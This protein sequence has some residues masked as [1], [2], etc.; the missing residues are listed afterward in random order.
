MMVSKKTLRE[1]ARKIRFLL[2]DVDG[3]MTNGL[4]YL[5]ELGKEMKAFHIHDGH[6]I[7][8]LLKARLGVGIVTG[9]ESRVVALRARELGVKEVHQGALDK[10]TV[11]E[12]ILRKYTMTDEQVA[13][14]GD[15]LIDIPVMRRTGLSVAV[16][17]AVPEVKKVAHFVTRREGGHGAVREVAD[18]LLSVQRP[19]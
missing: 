1:R 17:N 11:Y 18:L 8:L 12:R 5:D 15:D 7:L 16:A 3:V 4:L 19:Q 9:R 10:L 14:V 6:G 2:L 13:F